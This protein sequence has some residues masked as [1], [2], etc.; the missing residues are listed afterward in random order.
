MRARSTSFATSGSLNSG[1]ASRATKTKMR[2][3]AAIPVRA[4]SVMTS[5]IA[6]FAD[7]PPPHGGEGPRRPLR[8][9]RQDLHGR[10]SIQAAFRTDGDRVTVR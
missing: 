1:S 2:T 6:G 8:G 5:S 7:L 9:I 10:R 3:T 4:T